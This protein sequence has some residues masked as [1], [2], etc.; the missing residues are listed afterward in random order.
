MSAFLQQAEEIFAT[1]RTA[2]AEDSEMAVLVDHAG[3]IRLVDAAGW[4]T[5]ALRIDR[6]ARAVYRISRFRGRVR[7]EGRTR[8][9]CCFLDSAPQA[10]NPSGTCCYEVLAM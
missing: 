5:E 10:F 7:L 9:Q 1:A 8:G 6:G 3:G 4:D 2:G